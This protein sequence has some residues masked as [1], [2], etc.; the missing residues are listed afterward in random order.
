MGNAVGED[1]SQHHLQMQLG[2]QLLNELVA[3]PIGII[4]CTSSPGGI[5]ACHVVLDL[6]GCRNYQFGC[7]ILAQWE[8]SIEDGEL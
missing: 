6:S 3:A 7:D 4:P 2:W 8:I 5:A 1:L